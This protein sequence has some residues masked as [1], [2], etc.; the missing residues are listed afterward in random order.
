MTESQ[1]KQGFSENDVK[2]LFVRAS[3]LSELTKLIDEYIEATKTQPRIETFKHCLDEYVHMQL[4]SRCTE[5]E[6][7]EQQVSAYMGATLMWHLLK[8]DRTKY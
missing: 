7:M 2:D 5:K 8:N 1:K 6:I 3:S 4:V